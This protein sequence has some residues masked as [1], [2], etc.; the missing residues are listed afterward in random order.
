MR[1]LCWILV[2][3]PT[4]GRAAETIELAPPGYEL[5]YGERAQFDF[6]PVGDY[7]SVHLVLEVRMDSPTVS[8]S[9]HALALEV[10][11]QPLQGALSRTRTRLLNKPLNATMASGLEIPWVRGHEWRVVY[12]P[13]FEIVN[14]EAAGSNRIL[15]HSAYRLVL[16]I[17]DLVTRA[18]PL[19]HRRQ[20]GHQLRQR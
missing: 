1:Y 6:E 17:T 7:G 8:G 18:H 15:E 13:D 2:L 19:A 20:S 4:L 14:S 9:T 10:N 3:L 5:P 16:D 11:A 12:A